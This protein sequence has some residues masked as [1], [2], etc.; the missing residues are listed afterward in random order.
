MS[1]EHSVIMES[2]EASKDWKDPEPDGRVFPG[3]QKNLRISNCAGQK[4]ISIV[5]LEV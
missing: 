4:H 5:N 3:L 2:Q 1:L